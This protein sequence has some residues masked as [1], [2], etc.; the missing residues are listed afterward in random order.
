ML[1]ITLSIDFYALWN[2]FALLKWHMGYIYIDLIITTCMQ[3]MQRASQM[4]CVD[5]IVSSGCMEKND[6]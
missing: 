3:K 2:H 6:V 5:S 4:K 1:G